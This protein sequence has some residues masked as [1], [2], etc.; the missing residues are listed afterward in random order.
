MFGPSQI[1]A[2]AWPDSGQEKKK[3]GEDFKSIGLLENLGLA[4]ELLQ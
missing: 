2:L 3:M 4:V 1:S